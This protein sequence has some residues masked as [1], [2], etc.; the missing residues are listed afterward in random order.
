METKTI[1]IRV[2]P[3]AAYAY[4]T[5]SPEGRRD[6]RVVRRVDLIKTIEG[7]G[8][9]QVTAYSVRCAPASGRA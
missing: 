7:F 5:A 6:G 1:T 2:S 4:E 9:V 8:C 3:E